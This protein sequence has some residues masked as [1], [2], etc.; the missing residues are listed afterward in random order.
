[1][2]NNSSNKEEEKLLTSIQKV[3]RRVC[4]HM[5]EDH[6]TSLLAYARFYSSLVHATMPI[7][8]TQMTP[9]GFI[10]DVTVRNSDGTTGLRKDVLVK[11]PSGRMTKASQAHLLAISMHN[12]AFDG[13]GVIFKL[14][15]G[16]YQSKAKKS[17]YYLLKHKKY[18]RIMFLAQV[19]ACVTT[20]LMWLMWCSK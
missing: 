1:M 15:H 8:M 9:E 10:L 12:E 20:M 5:N 7:K 11:Y 3:E 2:S 16:Y 18:G 13:L 6:Q 17:I 4:R 14:Q 19:V